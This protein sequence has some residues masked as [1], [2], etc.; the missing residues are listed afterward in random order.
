[1]IIIGDKDKIKKKKIKIKY[2]ASLRQWKIDVHLVMDDDNTIEYIAYAPKLSFLAE[3]IKAITKA[4]K[5]LK[6]VL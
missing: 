5:E 2:I 3:D 6:Y 1:M 4:N